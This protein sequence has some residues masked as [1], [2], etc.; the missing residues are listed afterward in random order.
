MEWNT[1]D[2]G[3]LLLFYKYWSN[4]I[5]STPA[6]TKKNNESEGLLYMIQAAPS[7]LINID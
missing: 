2:Q 6:C 5:I 7:Y 1:E 3:G 4:E